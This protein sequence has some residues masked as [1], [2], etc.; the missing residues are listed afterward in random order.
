MAREHQAC[1]AWVCRFYLQSGSVLIN[2]LIHL[3]LPGSLTHDS[4]YS[5]MLAGLWAG[6][7]EGGDREKIWPAALENEGRSMSC[8]FKKYKAW[9]LRAC[10]HHFALQILISWPVP[11]HTLMI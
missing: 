7:Q 11:Q 6:R 8:P 4:S 2:E 9:P 1:L 10:C 3:S 5:V